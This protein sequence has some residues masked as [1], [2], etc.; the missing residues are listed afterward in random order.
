MLAKRGW[1]FLLCATIAV[2]FYGL[3]RPPLMGADEPRYAQVA[4]EMLIRGDFVTPTLGGYLWFEKPALLYWTVIASYRAFGV[5]EWSARVGMACAGVLIVLL[6][7]WLGGRLERDA[8]E[9]MCWLGLASSAVMASSAGLIVFS[10]GVNF[11]V[12]ITMTVTAA[13]ACFFVS[14]I[15]TNEGKRRWLLAGF[16]AGAGASL[17][18]KGLV[19]IVIPFGVVAG[20]FMLRRRWPG[21]IKIG[22][23]W[24][25]FLTVAV[26][27]TWY[28]PVI[29]RHGWVFIDE[30]F[31]Q[32]HFARYVSNKY[33]HPQP[34]YFYIPIILLLALPWTV[35]LVSA[36]KRVARWNWRA[37]DA[38]GKYRVFAL[39][40]LV[41]PIAFFSLSG[42]KLPGYI[43][44]ALPGAALL[45]AERLIHFLQ[46]KSSTKPM[47]AT[48]A[49]MLLLAIA[50]VIYAVR[51]G[52]V[53]LGCA[54]LIVTPLAIAG[55]FTL[56]WTRYYRSSVVLA[57]GAMFMTVPLIVNCAIDTVTRRESVRDL[58]Q[59]AAERGYATSP[60][61]GLHTIERSAE[62]YA[63]GRL[64]YDAKGEPVK[65][66][67]VIHVADAVRQSGE[68]V[69][70]IVPVEYIWQLT[71][72]DP[73]EADIIGNNDAV[74]LVAARLRDDER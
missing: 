57:V 52:N 29:A 60:V 11:D 42:S 70:V 47:R 50:G 4:R 31:V 3:G 6:V 2:Y 15:E 53:S 41:V 19:G 64:A 13:L 18:A 25:W 39:A 55:T 35:F 62:F 30:F 33:H 46:H 63:A 24:G 32:H 51:T 68:P 26:A 74:A 36:L 49:L 69:L 61:V 10:R 28:A 8:G 12:L 16:Y 54:L 22:A 14:E 7:G 72:Y 56:V 34:F 23:L 66:E 48:G 38:R 65:L 21:F 43:L 17:L 37:E 40:W 44:L 1:L 71:E 67:G 27:A 73:L 58:L 5:S 45:A 20:Y 9:E 59:L